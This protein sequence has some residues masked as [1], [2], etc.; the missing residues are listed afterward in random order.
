MEKFD[1]RK[2]SPRAQQ[3]IRYHVIRL[4]EKGLKRYGIS[5]ITGVHPSTISRWWKTYNESGKIAL[6]GKKQGC[7]TIPNRTLPPAREKE[8]QKALM[9][10]CP[11]QMKLPFSLWTR[12]PVRQLIKELYNIN[13]PI[14]TV[15]EYLK[16]WEFTPQKPLKKAISHLRKLQKMPGR[17][18]ISY[19]KHLKIV[20]AA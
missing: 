13:M 4:R 11:N 7:P 3:E 8:I 18:S 1:A 5:E 17:V 12:K 10:K 20:Y 9:D 2:L 19:F 6:K 14:R 16:N 15:G